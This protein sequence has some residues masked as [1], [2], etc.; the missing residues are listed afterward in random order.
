MYFIAAA[1]AVLLFVDILLIAS[2][3]LSRTALRVYLFS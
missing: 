3:C 1:A 2:D